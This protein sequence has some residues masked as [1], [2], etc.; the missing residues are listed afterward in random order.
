M[1]K[2]LFRRHIHCSIGVY[3]GL[4][5]RVIPMKPNTYSSLWLT[6]FRYS[7]REVILLFINVWISLDS[8]DTSPGSLCFVRL[9]LRLRSFLLRSG[10]R[11]R[12]LLG[13][14]ENGDDRFRS[15][16]RAPLGPG[17]PNNYF[18]NPLYSIGNNNI[19]SPR[20]LIGGYELRE[21][22]DEYN[23]LVPMCILYTRAICTVGCSMH[24][25]FTGDFHLR[26]AT[27]QFF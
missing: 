13:W 19:T 11:S 26:S 25:L 14:A 27:S 6:T 5:L 8:G 3:T 2:Y 4:E 16:D 21:W 10:G 17:V 22:G 20:H 15:P 7:V 18:F 23:G 24:V 1:C 9:H 12:L